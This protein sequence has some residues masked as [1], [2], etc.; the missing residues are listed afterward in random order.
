M[1]SSQRKQFIEYFN[2]RLDSIDYC[3]LTVVNAFDDDTKGLTDGSEDLAKFDPYFS[4][5]RNLILIGACVLVEDVLLR[6]GTDIIPDF[7]VHVSKIKKGCKI[8]KYL[9]V[10][11]D[12][13]TIDFT[14]INNDLQLIDDIVKIRNGIAHAGGKIDS[15]YNRVILRSIIKRRNWVKET[16]K[17][18]IFLNNDAYIEATKPVLNL[19]E[20]IL[21]NVTVLE[22]KKSEQ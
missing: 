1:N 7:K 11:K 18:Y 12:H 14:P 21:D 20:H 4:T 9:K 22:D 5:F 2:E 8:R 6:F 13:F 10:L 17:G 15:C 19:V 3:Y 16:D